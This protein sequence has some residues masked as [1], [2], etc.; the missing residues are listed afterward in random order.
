MTVGIV[1]KHGV[2][3]FDDVV[4]ERADAI[5]VAARGK[6]LEGADADVTGCHADQDT[7]RQ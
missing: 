7:A 5:H 4:G 1:A 6:V 2:V 3:T